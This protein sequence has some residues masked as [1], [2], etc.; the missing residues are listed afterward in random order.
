MNKREAVKQF[1]ELILTPEF[2]RHDKPAVREAWN[3]FMNSLHR[4]GMIT[5]R[6]YDTWS[7]TLLS[8]SDR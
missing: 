8:K 2:P 6:Q 3:N 7:N 4:E 1:K 5:D